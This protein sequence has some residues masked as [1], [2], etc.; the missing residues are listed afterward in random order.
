MT[1]AEKG[2]SHRRVVRIIVSSA[3]TVTIAAEM[4]QA[5]H[6]TKWRRQQKNPLL[7]QA[8]QLKDPPDPLRPF[9]Q[10]LEQCPPS[11]TLWAAA[12]YTQLFVSKSQKILK[13]SRGK[14]QVVVVW[15]NQNEDALCMN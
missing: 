11:P 13:G 3:V 2:K 10:Q 12:K 9:E 4:T 15:E 5:A 1:K 7:R 8:Q 14:Q 6:K